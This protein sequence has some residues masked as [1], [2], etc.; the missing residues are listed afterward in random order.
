MVVLKDEASGLEE[1]VDEER[2]WRLEKSP[3][4]YQQSRK[5]SN[6]DINKYFRLV[7]SPSV[8]ETHQR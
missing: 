2:V 4:D 7:P 1:E 8:L 3:K 5:R 6:K